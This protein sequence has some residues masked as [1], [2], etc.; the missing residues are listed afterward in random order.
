MKHLNENTIQ[1]FLDGELSDA[2]ISWATEHIA[3]CE[4][5]TNE[6][7]KAESEVAEIN[8]AFAAE[9]SVGIPT[10]RIWARIE[11]E[12][13]LLAVRDCQSKAET[14]SF[15]QQLA[16]FFTPPQI[17]FTGSLAGIVLIALFALSVLEQRQNS[18]PSDSLAYENH[19]IEKPKTQ[20]PNLT[21]ETPLQRTEAPD[22]TTP[23]LASKNSSSSSSSAKIIKAS[24]KSWSVKKQ[25]K[26]SGYERNPKSEIRNSRFE[27]T[28]PL[29][30][31]KDYLT[32]IAQLSKAVSSND[33]LVMRPSFRV[34]YESNLA[35][36][37]KVIGE[38]QKQA[39]RNPNDENAKRT[40]FASY[41]N[42]I[43]L[44]NTVA[45][46]SQLMASVR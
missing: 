37:D 39:R 38:T 36:M 2:Q 14:K 23:L 9:K 3:L 44:L 40:L 12:I 22:Q 10:Q 27:D 20:N 16:S 25:V 45:E 1:A 34:E 13:D 35:M 8:L 24:Y 17:A 18:M 31:E 41:Q 28:T 6:L 21:L 7:I 46:K 42:K 15:W 32:S 29:L 11:N 33:D 4:R 26:T 19:Q 5:C 30:E 43:D